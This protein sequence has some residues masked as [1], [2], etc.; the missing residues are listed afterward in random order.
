MLPLHDPARVPVPGINAVPIHKTQS[1][2]RRFV[3]RVV[4]LFHEVR[5]RIAFVGRIF[6]K[7]TTFAPLSANSNTFQQRHR[8]QQHQ[9]AKQTLRRIAFAGFVTLFAVLIILMALYFLFAWLFSTA[10]P[11]LEL[12]QKLEG[13]DHAFHDSFTNHE[14]DRRKEAVRDAFKHAWSGYVKYAWTHDEI[15]PVSN[16][17]N[18]SWGGWGVTMIDAL[19]T[20]VLMDLQDLLPKCDEHI[21][22]LDFVRD[23][24]ISVFETTIRYLGGLISAYDLTGNKLYLKKAEEL[25]ELLLYAF[26]SPSGLAYHET[27]TKSGKSANAGWVGMASI[28]SEIGSIQLEF[29]RLALITSNQA[30]YDTM[31]ANILLLRTRQEQAHV[32]NPNI[33]PKGLYPVKLKID[34]GIFMTSSKITFGGLADSFY[35]YLLKQ[36]LLTGQKEH[37]YLEWYLD[38]INSMIKYLSR[39]IIYGNQTYTFITEMTNGE[40][41]MDFEHLT[42][43]VPGMIALG[44]QQVANLTTYPREMRDDHWKFADQV[45]RT[46][47]MLY[48]TQPTGIAPD[49]VRFTDNGFTVTNPSYYLRPETIESLFYFYHITGD[50]KYRD[51]GWRIFQNILKYCRTPSAFSGLKDVTKI[52]ALQNNSMQSFFLAET[53]KYFYL[54]F[55]NNNNNK[56][57]LDQYVLNTEGHPFKITKSLNFARKN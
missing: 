24:M 46:C 49:S 18:D 35:E 10:I 8:Y 32:E 53:L 36:Y 42:C 25:S 4:K 17:T 26:E 5:K 47:I 6:Q 3:N 52:P 9:Q 2:I 21:K 34:D 40:Q 44:T 30:L 7:G 19:D 50:Q 27:N 13:G 28:L 15:R 54:L 31:S 43:F 57:P 16:I 23:K 14:N 20:I 29:K 55:S 37:Q 33:I 41:V 1:G 12:L 45:L 56:L 11:M 39:D 48:D 38:S 51:I 22:D